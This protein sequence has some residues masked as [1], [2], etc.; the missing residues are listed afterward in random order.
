MVRWRSRYSS[1]ENARDAPGSGRCLA[2]EVTSDR[3]PPPLPNPTGRCNPTERFAVR[4][5]GGAGCA[6]RRWTKGSRWVQA[7]VCDVFAVTSCDFSG[8]NVG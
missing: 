5:G 8:D 1:P 7:S 3:P 2:A 6:R 4:R